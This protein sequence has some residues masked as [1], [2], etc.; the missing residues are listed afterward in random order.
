MAC[1]ILLEFHGD[2]PQLTRTIFRRE[3]GQV[4]TT[5]RGKTAGALRGAGSFQWTSAVRALS[6]LLVRGALSSV[7]GLPTTTVALAG[8]G[9]SLASTLDYALRKQ[10]L[11]TN[12]M[13]GVDHFS[14]AFLRRIFL[15]TN[16]ERKYPGPVIVT[17]N[18]RVLP[19]SH[20]QIWWNGRRVVETEHY[21]ELLSKIEGTEMLAGK[22][23]HPSTKTARLSLNEATRPRPTA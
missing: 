9:G 12:E 2:S 15:R 5:V 11:W 10:P 22:G 19:L 23:E 8:L 18:D 7:E 6:A 17:I 20:I 1:E 14:Q 16:P 21:R 13:C 4:M 3:S